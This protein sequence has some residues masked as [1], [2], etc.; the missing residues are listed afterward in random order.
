EIRDFVLDGISRS[1]MRI[2]KVTEHDN[3][4][5]LQLTDKNLTRNLGR[6]LQTK[7]GGECKI[8]TSLYGQKDGKEIYRLTVLFRSFGLKKGDKV[9]YK[10]ENYE[11]KL[12]G[13]DLLLQD[14]SSGKKIHVKYGEMGNFKKVG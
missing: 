4:V 2:S 14:P 9:S 8:S 1:G 11:I 3:G 13:K 12:L 6:M 7:F 10:G 5:D